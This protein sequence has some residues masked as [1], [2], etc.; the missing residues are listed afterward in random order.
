M[1][2]FPPTA[3]ASITGTFTAAAQTITLDVPTG[4]SNWLV[5]TTGTFVGNIIA[6]LSADGVNYVPVNSRQSLAGRIAN[7]WSSSGIFRGC[8]AGGLKF[9]IRSTTWTSGTASST[10]RLT[11]GASPSF[12]N[13]IVEIRQLEQYY[14]AVAGGNVAFSGSV[15]AVTMATTGGTVGVLHNPPASTID[16]YIS[17]VIVGS[18]KAGRFERYRTST[19]PTITGTFVPMSNKGGATNTSSSR[20]YMP[21]AATITTT[22][23][24]LSKTIFLNGNTSD[25]TIED[26][27]SILR[28]GQSLFWMYTPDTNQ[29]ALA[30]L[31]LSF[32]E[33][34]LTT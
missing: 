11:T 32:W 2:F 1:S 16:V 5:Q 18:N 6:E 4:M 8:V 28:P 15:G 20:L 21:N 34:S 10:I 27:G 12:Q 7:N 31:D 25:T 19:A 29:T 23:A 9:R 13:S 22:G 26:G 17:R 30:T 33:S 3:D 14:A 24:T